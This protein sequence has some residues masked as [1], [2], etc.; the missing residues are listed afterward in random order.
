MMPHDG[1]IIRQVDDCDPRAGAEQAVGGTPGWILGRS[2]FLR[3]V[4][5][6]V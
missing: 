4:M 2:G 5:A 1:Q 3:R 6:T